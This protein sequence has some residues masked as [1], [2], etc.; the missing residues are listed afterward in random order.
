M[1]VKYSFRLALLDIIIRPLNDTK[2]II[3][4]AKIRLGQIWGKK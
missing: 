2:K 4:A 3:G 1:N